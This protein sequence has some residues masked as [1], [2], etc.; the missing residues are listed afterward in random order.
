[1]LSAGSEFLR[2]ISDISER[3]PKI[4]RV[5]C[6][7]PFGALFMPQLLRQYI[8]TVGE[9][10]IDLKEGNQRQLRDW[11]AEGK[12]E[13]AVLYDGD[14][15]SPF[16]TTPIC[17][18]PPHAAL[19]IDDPL[20]KR[21]AVE[22]KDLAHYPLVLLDLPEATPHILALFSILAEVPK[23]SFRTRSYETALSAISSGFGMSLLNMRPLNQLRTDGP[24][25]VRRPILDDLP[26]AKLIIA[27][28]YGSQKPYFLSAFIDVFRKFFRDLGPSRFAVS[29]HDREAHLL[30]EDEQPTNVI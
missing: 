11:L 27:D 21:N 12:I 9:T 29:T 15:I 19:H 10:E 18:I 23:I 14:L 25:I 17:L 20:A 3:V 13:M 26:P 24:N 6:F 30:I 2:T 28:P 4:L 16:S 5:G 22:V 1:M 8:E 7:E